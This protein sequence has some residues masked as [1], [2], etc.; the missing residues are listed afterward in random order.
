MKCIEE[1][2]YYF[3]L[4]DFGDGAVFFKS[5]ENLFIINSPENLR[6]IINSW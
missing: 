2:D 4:T 3:S 5:N 6:N 1:S